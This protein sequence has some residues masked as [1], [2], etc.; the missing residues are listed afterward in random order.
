MNNLLKAPILIKQRI[1]SPQEFRRGSNDRFFIRFTFG[2]FLKVVVSKIRAA[3]LHTDGHYPC[4]STVMGISSFRYSP[5]CL[6]SARL[7][8]YRIKTTETN[9]FSVISKSF[10]IHKLCHKIDGVFLTNTRNRT[11]DFYFSLKKSFCLF[12][13]LT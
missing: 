13:N 2:P 11:K 6:E 8:N 4:Y 12:F 7:L 10:N 3:F 1:N 5:A 9:K